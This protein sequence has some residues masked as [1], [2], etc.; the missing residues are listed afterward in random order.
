MIKNDVKVKLK[1]RKIL[2]HADK[3]IETIIVFGFQKRER[4]NRIL[5]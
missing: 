3:K 5:F 2:L 4:K 1:L